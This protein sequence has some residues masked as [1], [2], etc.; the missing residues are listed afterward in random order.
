MPKLP[1]GGNADA[2]RARIAALCRNRLDPAD[3][4]REVAE[5]VRC[6]VPYDMGTWAITDPETLLPTDL[7][8]VDTSGLGVQAT[9]A[10]NEFAGGDFNRFAELDRVGRAAA[11]LATA[12][13][14]DLDLSSRHRSVHAPNGLNDEMRLLAR[15]G[16]ATWA[17][18][19]LTRATD[20]PDFSPEEVRYVAAVA[21]ELG[22]GLRVVLAR[23]P[24]AAA[25]A[26]R[27]GMLVLDEAGRIE[28]T[29]READRW[30]HRM[31]PPPEGETPIAIAIVALQ[32]QAQAQ[33]HGTA[34]EAPRAARLRLR[35]PAGGWLL[36]HADV[37]VDGAGLSP[38]TAV[39]LEPAGPAQMLPLLFALYGLTG[40]ER[41][42]TEYL[43]AGHKTA[44]I[45]ERMWISRHTLRDH[46]K[47]IF[48]KMNV[49]SRPELTAILGAEAR[50]A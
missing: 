48:A 20:M 3:L 18:G 5:Q 45:A 8:T 16:G 46:M 21:S 22:R 19:C 38:R 1:L 43:I 14:G 40:R 41:Q 15:D 26:G 44:E 25:C 30:I 33:A 24:P 6:I 12:T 10:S 37:L 32:A 31:S 36:V 4:V 17:V 39:M 34:D 27:P 7:L 13:G 42:V 9:K 35:L 47:S 23:N 2:V 11:T 49:G 50:S 29:T 28:A